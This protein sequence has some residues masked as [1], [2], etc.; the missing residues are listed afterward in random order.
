MR[1]LATLLLS[2]LLLAA[3][4]N[5]EGDAVGECSDGADNDRDGRYDCDDPDCFAS[6]SCDGDDDD[7]ASGDD[8]DTTP[9]DDDDATPG[10]DDDATAGDDDDDDAV[11]TVDVTGTA[12]F[13]VVTH[14]PQFE[15][16][17]CV[18]L[19]AA[20][21]DPAAGTMVG[22]GECTAELGISLEVPFDF[23]VHLGQSSVTGSGTVYTSDVTGN[24]LEDLTLVVVGDYEAEPW[25]LVME[26]QGSDGGSTVT[27]SGTISLSE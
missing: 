12:D 20:V 23:D 21:V 19:A 14:M 6:P 16:F 4:A 11:D 1:E 26:A 18:G 13:I 10:D 8:D 15:E 24:L 9:A 22:D 3:C 2:G 17:D 25:E 5:V 27:I 7:S